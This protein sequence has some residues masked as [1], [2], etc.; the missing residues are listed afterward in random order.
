M[1]ISK[2]AVGVALAAV[3][4]TQ[5]WTMTPV[6]AQDNGERTLTSANGCILILRTFEQSISQSEMDQIRE[7][8]VSD[9]IRANSVL[10]DIDNYL[11]AI[12]IPDLSAGGRLVSFGYKVK[13]DGTTVQF[14]AVAMNRDSVNG[15]WEDGVEWYQEK[16]AEPSTPTAVY[17]ARSPNWAYA[18]WAEHTIWD[19]PYGNV[20]VNSYFNRLNDDGSST[21]D[22]Y[23]DLT[24]FSMQPGYIVSGNNWEN[25]YGWAIQGW[26]AS[27]FADVFN[28]YLPNG[29]ITGSYSNN[30]NIGM[31][32]GYPGSLN[33]A[34][35]WTYTQY[36]TSEYCQ[37]NS[38]TRQAVWC[39]QYNS[40]AAKRTSG[41][42]QPSSTMRIYQPTAGYGQCS[43]VNHN[44]V[45]RFYNGS[46]THDTQGGFTW[47]VF[48]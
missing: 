35:S 43:I 13:P 38:T 42:N 6:L 46:Y 47:A 20:I 36:D 45:G 41:G 31:S 24:F 39:L 15:A 40:V 37:V 30:W 2:S 4:L 33:A 1:K 10:A 21:Y 9:A 27:P 28:E 23:G 8:A 26:D 34:F 48:Y 7:T 18:S 44:G 14:T 12:A 25:Q 17:S 3:L 22:W 5:V 16:Q 11:K 29:S 32:A 19:A